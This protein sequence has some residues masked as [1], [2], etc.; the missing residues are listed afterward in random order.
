ME[1]IAAK[2]LRPGDRILAAN[3]ETLTIYDVVPM[4]EIRHDGKPF[5]TNTLKPNQAVSVVA[6]TTKKHK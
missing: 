1:R 5:G 2:D 4:I 3:G 6:R